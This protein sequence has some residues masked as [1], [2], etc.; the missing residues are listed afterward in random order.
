[1]YN[2]IECVTLSCD[3]CGE[4]YQDEHGTGFSIW[5]HE[6]GVHD[7][8]DSDGWYLHG[9]EDKHYCPECHTINDNDELVINSL[10]WE[11]KK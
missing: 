1:M 10:D 2:K 7:S 6:S 9:E 5:V 8:A 4:I 3:N 11:L